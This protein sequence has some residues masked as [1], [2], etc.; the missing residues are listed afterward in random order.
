MNGQAEGED[1]EK[2][3]PVL[4]RETLDGLNLRKGLIYV[5]VTAGG[6]GH[7]RGMQ[8]RLKAADSQEA[9]RIGLEIVSENESKT[10]SAT[11]VESGD[12]SKGT[13]RVIGID[14]DLHSLNAL[15]DRVGPDVT[16]IHANFAEITEKLSEIGVNT[17]TG[18]ILADLGVSSMQLDQA[19]RGF[20]FMKDGPLD[21]RMDPTQGFSAED[22][23]NKS[24]EHEL[25]DIIYKYGEERFSRQ[26]AR[27]IVRMRPLHTTS[28]LA[29]VVSRSLRY[30]KQRTAGHGKNRSASGDSLHLATRTFQAIRIAVNNELESLEKFLQDATA[31]LAPG[32][33]LAVITFHSLEDRMVKQFLRS[34][35]TECICPPRQPVC[36]CHHNSEMLIITRKPIVADEKEVLANV[37][38]R[39]A[40]LRLGQKL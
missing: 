15:R 33:R 3:V 5:D 11:G 18:G 23:I 19:E 35:A 2:H 7:L 40:K 34:A 38:S 27:E 16:L 31:L 32:A 17:V 28:E 22:L 4:L 20:S 9:A 29:D 13:S 10:E 26:I 12:E 6:G 37:R 8:E 30:Q 36:T 39:S 14:R 21:M 25:A 24:S 1:A